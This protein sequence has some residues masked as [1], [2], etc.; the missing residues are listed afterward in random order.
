MPAQRGT[1]HAWLPCHGANA[2]THRAPAKAPFRLSPAAN[3]V[4]ARKGARAPQQ[5]PRIHMPHA[6]GRWLFG[7]PKDVKD[8]EAFHKLSLVA[9]LAW[10][11]L[12]ADGLSS[13]AYGPD[14]AF[15]A[16][17]EPTGFALFLAAATAGTVLVISSGY[18][19]ISEQFP[20]GGGGYV[21]ASRLLSPE[22][23]VASGAALLVDYVLT[24][25]ISIASGADAVFSFIPESLHWIKLPVAFAGVGLLT[26]MNIRGVKES[27]TALVPV[28][29]LFVISH[30]VLLV[31]AIGGHLGDG[32]AG[33]TEAGTNQSPQRAARRRQDDERRPPRTDRGRLVDRGGS[34]RRLVR[35]RLAAHR[36]SSPLR[37]GAGRVP[38]WAARHGEHGDRFVA[39]AP[40]R[41]AVRPPVDAQW[42]RHHGVLRVRRARVHARRRVK[43]RRHVLDQRLLDVQ[44]VEPGDDPVLD[45]PS[46]RARDV[47]QAPRRAPGRPGLVRHH[48]R[49]HDHRE[50]RRRRLGDDARDDDPRHR[51]LHG[52]APL[53]RR[54]R[55]PPKARR[56][57]ALPLRG[58][59]TDGAGF[60]PPGSHLRILVRVRRDPRAP[61]ASR[62][63]RSGPEQGG[64]DP[65]RRRLQRPR[66]ARAPDA[67]SHVPATLQ[68]D[69][70]RQRRRRRLRVI[71]G[72]RPGRGPRGAYARP[73]PQLR[74]LRAVARS[75][76][77]ERLRVALVVEE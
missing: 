36:R 74:A 19:R 42:R 59:G 15:R 24:I 77:V 38:R 43:A 44:P 30:I 76:G 27:V 34:R 29:A 60:R 23:G 8:P 45:H 72:R 10:V 73:P 58:R 66:S 50:V 13:S 14:E 39:A 68:R 25:T 46:T 48:P 21:V 57:A 67:P 55:S 65:A 54:G 35:G 47:V 49:D 64:R 2:G 41:R 16:L 61:R 62:G 12:G 75:D 33:A 52:Q 71:Q 26:V 31:V 3:L 63:A 28:F 1:H 32:G 37:G 69:H 40:L 7:A 4:D 18:S 6:I 20:S 56:R 70:L 11:G 53:P 9:L 22:V 5:R 17:G 51:L